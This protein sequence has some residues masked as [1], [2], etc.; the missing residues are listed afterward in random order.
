MARLMLPAIGTV[1]H[2]EGDLEDAYRAAGWVDA[3]S[4]QLVE[5]PP[6]KPVARRAKKAVEPKE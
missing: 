1:V 4:T 5:V 2:L 3:D 6:V